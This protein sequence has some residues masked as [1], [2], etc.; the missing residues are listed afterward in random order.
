MLLAGL[1]PASFLRGC[2]VGRTGG[3]SWPRRVVFLSAGRSP[4]AAVRC[5][6][7]REVWG[8]LL[9]RGWWQ[10]WDTGSWGQV[11][12]MGSHWWLWGGDQVMGR[13]LWEGIP[14]NSQLRGWKCSE[15]CQ[16]KGGI[17]CPWS[18]LQR[19]D[20]GQQLWGGWW[21][22]S[23]QVSKKERPCGMM[24]LPSGW[25]WGLWRGFFQATSS[26][27]SEALVFRDLEQG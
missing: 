18:F 22:Q 3:Y 17:Q 6:H 8:L 16:K 4:R 23:H 15:T 27:R 19:H 10:F 12:E 9:Y 11:R 2:L 14:I 25:Q 13:V 21:P 5:H 7:C 24:L 1:C 26:R 20:G